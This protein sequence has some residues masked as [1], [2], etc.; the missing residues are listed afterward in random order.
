LGSAYEMDIFFNIHMETG[1]KETENP[2]PL[3]P[4]QDINSII[5]ILSQMKTWSVDDI[6]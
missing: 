2:D 4:I 6:R 5:G 3:I 1:I